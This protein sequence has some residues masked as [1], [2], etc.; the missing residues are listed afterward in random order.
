M[1]DLVFMGTATFALPS[2]QAVCAAGHRVLAVVTQPD[3]P[4]GRGLRVQPPPV[5]ELALSLGL[6]VMQPEKARDPD[7][8][9]ALQRLAPQA[10]VVVAYGQILRRAVLDLPP[11]GCV[12]L[13]ASLL[14]ELR[15]AAPIAWAILRGYRET[16]NTTIFM[17]EGMDTGD[18]ILQ[19]REPISPDDT[20][21][22]L[23][24]RL[25]PRGAEL[26]CRTLA[27]IEAGRAP[28]IPQD[29]ARA[30]YAP[31]LTPADGCIDW[32]EP[33]EAIRNRIHGCNPVPGATATRHGVRVKLWRAAAV[34]SDVAAPP[35]TVIAL[36]AR[37]PLLRAGEGA[38]LLRE[39]QVE[40]RGRVTGSEFV[41][42]Y[43]PQVGERWGPGQAD[44]P[45]A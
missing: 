13:H 15:G 36:T 6:P 24:H 39:L 29:P 30:T 18:I 45:R 3:R 5:K 20:A 43:R 31:M 28:R 44:A 14:P 8:V 4:H 26:L 27:L 25:A 19:E 42:G 33:A 7:F 12:N 17:D 37:G 16:G 9:A 23:A 10:I 40:G 21:G 34:D 35:G 11:L 2:L 38:V 41:R 22:D 32:G 1:L